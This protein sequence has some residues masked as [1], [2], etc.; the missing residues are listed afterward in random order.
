[1]LDCGGFFLFWQLGTASEMR[2]PDSEQSIHFDR[3][4]DPN[5]A[6]LELAYNLVFDANR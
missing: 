2:S 5:P 3:M 4:L 1:M 6:G